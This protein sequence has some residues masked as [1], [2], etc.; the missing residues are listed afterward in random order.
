[1]IAHRAPADRVEA[2]LHRRLSPAR[3][4][5]GTWAHGSAPVTCAWLGEGVSCLHCVCRGRAQ[6]VGRIRRAPAAPV[7]DARRAGARPRAPAAPLPAALEAALLQSP[8]RSGRRTRRPRRAWRRQGV[9][10]ARAHT[11]HPPTTVP[12]SRAAGGRHASCSAGCPAPRHRAGVLST[13][14]CSVGPAPSPRPSPVPAWDWAWTAGRGPPEQT[15]NPPSEGARGRRPR[16]RQRA[17]RSEI[18]ARPLLPRRLRC[19]L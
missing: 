5:V 17:A 8:S 15:V 18:L 14:R 11:A 13:E 9:A 1:M 10:V 12:M 2:W 3:G 7:G 6:P 16:P 4:N 19:W